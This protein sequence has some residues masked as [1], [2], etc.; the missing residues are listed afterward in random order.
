MPTCHGVSEAIGKRARQRSA[1]GGSPVNPFAMCGT[2]QEQFRGH[3]VRGSHELHLPRWSGSGGSARGDWLRGRASSGAR[4]SAGISACGTQGPRQAPA[5]Q[6]E[7]AHM[8]HP[9]TGIG[10]FRLASGRA[11][12]LRRDKG[13]RGRALWLRMGL[14]GRPTSPRSIST[15]GRDILRAPPAAPGLPFPSPSQA[16]SVS[17]SNSARLGGGEACSPVWVGGGR[18]SV[19]MEVSSERP[20]AARE[21]T[22][23]L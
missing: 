14:F 16:C 4:E 5:G 22:G 7:T 9:S 6:F 18:E 17:A 3:V 11:A 2:G 23:E 10:C 1:R 15:S 13:G 21:T 8:R 12:G 19:C 20:R